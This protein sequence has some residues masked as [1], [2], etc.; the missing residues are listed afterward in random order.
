MNHHPHQLNDDLLTRWIDGQLTPE[1]A[2]LVEQQA[3]AMPELMLDKQAAGHIGDLLRSH[4]PATLEPPSPDFFTSSIMEEIRRESPAAAAKPARTSRLPAWLRW[5]EIPWFAPLA[6]AAAVAV[7]FLLWN[8]A[9]APV[10]AGAQLAQTYA[11]DSKITASAWYSEEAGAT[12]IDLQNLDAVPDDREIKAF[13]VASADPGNPG[14]PTVL[15]AAADATRPVMVLSK[16]SRDT[17]RITTV[18]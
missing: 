10:Q 15:Y 2:A 13:D 17:P 8:Q 11:P 6:S 4:L 5:M 14:E 16:D 12:V 1:E 18:H 9:N 7:G 3:A